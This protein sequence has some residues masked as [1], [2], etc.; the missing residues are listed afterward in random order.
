M[1]STKAKQCSQS[2]SLLDPPGIFFWEVDEKVENAVLL[3][4]RRK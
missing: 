1:K 4:E 3:N 2:F